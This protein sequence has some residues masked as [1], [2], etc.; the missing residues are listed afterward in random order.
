MTYSLATGQRKGDSK[1]Q[2][3]S[4]DREKQKLLESEFSFTISKHWIACHKTDEYTDP[5][6]VVNPMLCFDPATKISQ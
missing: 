6:V 5:F 4:V 2:N 3:F 1:C